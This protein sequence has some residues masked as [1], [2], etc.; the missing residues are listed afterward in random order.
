MQLVTKGTFQFA[1]L[2]RAQYYKTFYVHNFRTFLI[3]WCF[4][5]GRPFQP[6]LVFMS[7]AEAYLSGALKGYSPQR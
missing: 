5:P 3:S 6:S 7:K 1:S 2:T 4:V